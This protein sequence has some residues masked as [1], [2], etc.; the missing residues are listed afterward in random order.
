MSGQLCRFEFLEFL[1]R[2]SETKFI[3]S[4]E[5]SEYPEA[6]GSFYESYCDK[7]FQ[8]FD[9]QVFRDGEYWTEEVDFVY[10][11][12]EPL[13]QF[14]YDRYSGKNTLPGKKP[15]MSLEELRQ[16]IF[17]IEIDTKLNERDIPLIFNLSMMT[18]VD[19][20]MGSRIFEMSF[21]EYLE[22]IARLAN[23]VSMPSLKYDKKK[24]VDL[25]E[26]ELKSQKLSFKCEAFLEY[27]RSRLTD[28]ELK[29]IKLP[30]AGVSIL[31]D[32]GLMPDD[33]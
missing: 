26:A 18:Q 22:A 17:N 11:S 5:T 6:I 30:K 3:M 27:L 16:F 9:S 25:E 33:E 19:E 31:T 23:L 32:D 20:L 13:L 21:V 24:V 10:K 7:F 15:F 28:N 14:Y 29:S 12:Y 2:C 4:K 1:V 8:G